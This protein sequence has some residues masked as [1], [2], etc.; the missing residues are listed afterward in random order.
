MHHWLDHILPTGVWR[1]TFCVVEGVWVGW[2][3][4]LRHLQTPIPDSDGVILLPEDLGSVFD[5]WRLAEALVS[6]LAWVRMY[7]ARDIPVRLRM[8][9]TMRRALYIDTSSR[10]TW[11]AMTTWFPET[12]RVRAWGVFR[13]WS[14]TMW[15]RCQAAWDLVHAETWPHIA[16]PWNR[17]VEERLEEA[18]FTDRMMRDLVHR[19]EWVELQEEEGGGGRK[20]RNEELE[21]SEGATE[22]AAETERDG[23]QDA[24]MAAILLSNIPLRALQTPVAIPECRILSSILHAQATLPLESRLTH[25]VKWLQ[26]ILYPL[27]FRLSVINPGSKTWT[28]RLAEASRRT[29]QLPESPVTYH[30]TLQVPIA[31][32]RREAPHIHQHRIRRDAGDDWVRGAW[33]IV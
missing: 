1:N 27:G 18:H 12:N 33:Y 19:L 29:P 23:I 17:Y 31:T 10:V 8:R 2:V 32:T 15:N 16:P 30:I 13:G 5:R 14:Q 22:V 3:S 7:I 4:G 9:W 25:P 28:V 24:C 11:M 6:H 26:A 21:S 20:R